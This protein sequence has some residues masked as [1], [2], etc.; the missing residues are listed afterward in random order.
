VTRSPRPDAREGSHQIGARLARETAKILTA[1]DDFDPD[2]FVQ[3]LDAV[4]PLELLYP[5][6]DE[7]TPE[8]VHGVAEAAADEFMAWRRGRQ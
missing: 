1:R 6:P 2:A 7:I 3:Y 8:W 4:R 5:L